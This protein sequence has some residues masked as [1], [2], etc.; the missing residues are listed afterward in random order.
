MLQVSFLAKTFQSLCLRMF[1]VVTFFDDVRNSY[2][3]GT[4]ELRMEISLQLRFIP[5][6]LCNVFLLRHNDVICFLDVVT[7]CN[8]VRIRLYF[9]TFELHME[10]T[11]QFTFRFCPSLYRIFHYVRIT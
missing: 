4:S 6:R 10:I 9:G 8:D 1:D 3:F 11:S 7:F 5:V 2:Y